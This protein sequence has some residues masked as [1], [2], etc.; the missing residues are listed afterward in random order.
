LCIIDGSRDKIVKIIVEI[1]R[2]CSK[3]RRKVQNLAYPGERN[4]CKKLAQMTDYVLRCCD[5]AIT[6]FNTLKHRGRLETTISEDMWTMWSRI[7]VWV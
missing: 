4:K 5:N 6:S 2:D 3:Y 1:K 7:G